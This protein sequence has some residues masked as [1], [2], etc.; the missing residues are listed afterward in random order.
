MNGLDL[1][2]LNVVVEEPHGATTVVEEEFDWL[3]EGLEWEDFDDNVFG[4]LSPPHSVPP[5]P[6]TVP[7]EP[8]DDR[9]QPTTD[10]PQPNTNTRPTNTDTP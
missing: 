6:N 8:T 1:K 4:V 5:E 7:P 3:N 10:T 9:P 2:I